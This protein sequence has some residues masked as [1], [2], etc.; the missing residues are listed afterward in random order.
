MKTFSLVI[1]TSILALFI[2]F[3]ASKKIQIN[4][5]LTQDSSGVKNE[6][7]LLRGNQN[8]TD[9]VAINTLSASSS[10]NISSDLTNFAA[11]F[12]H[13]S[14]HINLWLK[15][16]AIQAMK[17]KSFLELKGAFE[18]IVA[19]SGPG[20]Y[21]SS[22]VIIAAMFKQN[23]NAS[24]DY[25]VGV[26]NLRLKEVLFFT[27]LN[28]YIT[29]S[30]IDAVDWIL[31]QSYLHALKGNE[32]VMRSLF[33]N[34]AQI[35]RE[36]AFVYYEQ[37]HVRLKTAA[38]AGI[39]ST[40][41]TSED[42]QTFITRLS[43]SPH[44]SLVDGIKEL[45]AEA[46]PIEAS[47]WLNSQQTPS[48]R[49]AQSVY[50]SWLETDFV[51][52]ADWYLNINVNTESGLKM[53]HIMFRANSRVDRNSIMN[54]ISKLSPDDINTGYTSYFLSLSDKD[55]RF[56]IENLQLV[57]NADDRLRL[58]YRISNILSNKNQDEA[59]AF[60]NSSEFSTQLQA[61]SNR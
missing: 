34:L 21:A 27:Y 28:E 44:S 40:I 43:G 10:S 50:I 61:R 20:F 54:W 39:S 8:T 2:G 45:W 23:P 5:V 55:T 42:Y 29:D 37:I 16:R 17:N 57:A 4:E 25:L 24:L 26:K 1:F 36:L 12:S 9:I 6:V 31:K 35:D 53:R 51:A 32:G 48:P 38:I 58:S 59:E 30:P 49:V 41:T 46:F 14:F 7:T 18:Q 13:S 22:S 56:V 11:L 47:N 15:A 52:A 33:F 19:K 3:F 60:I